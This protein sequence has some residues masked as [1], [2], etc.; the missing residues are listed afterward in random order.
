MSP[1][2]LRRLDEALSDIDTGVSMSMLR[3]DPLRTINAIL[4]EQG[5]PM[6][7][8]LS[9]ESLERAVRLLESV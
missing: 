8:D 5:L 4:R 1:G 6:I 9:D 7:H 3:V 2:V